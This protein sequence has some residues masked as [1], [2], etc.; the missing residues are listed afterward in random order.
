MPMARTLCILTLAAAVCGGCGNDDSEGPP[1]VRIGGAV[2]K[3]E[4][5]T[6]Q[7]SRQRGLSGRTQLA[8]G[9]GMLF[10]FPRE[11]EVQFHMLNCHVP[12]DVAFISSR[13]TVVEIRRMPV[14]DDPADPKAFYPSR[15]PVR[16]ALEV[17]G[18]ELK[19][20]GVGV[21]DRVELL[22][23]ARNAAKDAR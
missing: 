21:G 22:G 9:T 1:A 3:V 11:E 5:A 8:R 17:G 13:L 15:R 7:A 6:D 20:L 19:R 23:A 16:Y 4:L 10:A 12:L 18:G 14:E 2:W